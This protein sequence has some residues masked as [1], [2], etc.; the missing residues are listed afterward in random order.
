MAGR[1]D[2]QP[3]HAAPAQ[4][5]AGNPQKEAMVP[6]S[7]RRRRKAPSKHSSQRRKERR[8][9]GEDHDERRTRGQ[10]TRWWYYRGRAVTYC[11]PGLESV[12]PTQRSL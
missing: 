1:N 5:G 3:G 2:G 9:R 4:E 8:K 11:P 10:P 7:H 12:N 6:S